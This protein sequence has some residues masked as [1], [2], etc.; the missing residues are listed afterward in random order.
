MSHF[1]DEKKRKENKTNRKSN[2]VD[3]P[4]TVPLYVYQFARSNKNCGSLYY[5]FKN[6]Y[7]QLNIIQYTRFLRA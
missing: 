6:G 7:V 2:S 1:V 5:K 3:H 4:S